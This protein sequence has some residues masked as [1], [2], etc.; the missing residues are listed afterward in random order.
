MVPACQRHPKLSEKTTFEVSP[1][2][3]PVKGFLCCGVRGRVA[4]RE[5]SEHR[6]P[7][8]CWQEMELSEINQP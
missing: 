5:Y 1:E 3:G 2:R 8:G 4:L 6:G 7:G